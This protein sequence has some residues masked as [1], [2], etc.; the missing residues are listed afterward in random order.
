MEKEKALF[1]GLILVLLFASVSALQVTTEPIEDVVAIELTIPAKYNVTIKN[2]LPTDQNF[3]IYALVDVELRP[4]YVFVEK[5]SEKS[6]VLEVLPKRRTEGYKKYDFYVRSQQNYM[7]LAESSVIMK[8]LPLEK[9]LLVDLPAEVS[10]EDRFIVLNIKNKENIR[11]TFPFN[12]TSELFSFSSETS[13]KKESSN[14]SIEVDLKKKHAGNYNVTFTAFLNNEYV[15]KKTIPVTLQ[16]V[17][18]I[19]ELKEKRWHFFGYTN[20]I[21]KRNDGNARK[22]VTIELPLSRIEN[23]FTSF[24]VQPSEKK[25]ENGKIVARWYQELQPG[26]SF[27]IEARTDYTVLAVIIII[28]AVVLIFYL[29]FFTKKV[30]I[31]KKAIRLRTKGDEFAAKVIL[32][33]KNIGKKEVRDVKL[34]DRLPATTKLY[35]KFGPVKPDKIEKTRLEWNFATILPGEEIVTSYIIYSK[36]GMTHVELPPASLSYV[37]EK[38]KRHTISSAKVIVL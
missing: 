18:K 26:E 21:T 22:V 36:V 23:A 8:V 16:E 24:N 28:I 12:I 34:I 32:V 25:K 20:I 37:D 15:F 5:N 13:L 33:A 4:E 29:I 30:L 7:I 17:S 9:I 19:S 10:R 31:K 11:L 3:S 6:F 1:F 27:T 35:E 2:D 38:N 14:F